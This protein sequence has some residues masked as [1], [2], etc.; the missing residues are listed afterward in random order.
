M[1]IEAYENTYS[2][3]QASDIPYAGAFSLGIPVLF[4]CPICKRLSAK[5]PW[6]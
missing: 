6:I 4:M 1:G 2:L 5:C 3:A